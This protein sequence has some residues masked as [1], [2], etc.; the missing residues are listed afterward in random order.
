[1]SKKKHE[2]HKLRSALLKISRWLQSIIAPELKYSQSIYEDILRKYVNKNII[3]LEIGCGH[4]ILPPWRE[5][6]EKYLAENS[7]NI[8]GI[9]YD[10]DSLR[11][12]KSIAL[13]VRGDISNLPFKSDHFELATANMVVEHLDKPETQF[14]EIHRVIRPNGIFLFHTPNIMS[15]EAIIARITPEKITTRIVGFLEGRKEKDIFKTYYRANSKSKIIR[16]A[17][18]AGFKVRKIKMI[19]SSPIFVL[20]PILVVFELL[21]IKLLMLKP[22]KYLRSNI[23]VVLNKNR[24][25]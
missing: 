11:D 10:M 24:A 9:D 14:M 13:R 16:L 17:S 22:L 7:G 15:L 21:W 4:N 23:I 6:E 12:N 19:V 2:S 25:F 1:L 20:I 18:T 5:K 8:I 3:W